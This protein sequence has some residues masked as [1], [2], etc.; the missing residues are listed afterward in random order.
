MAASGDLVNRVKQRI[1]SLLKGKWRL[2]KLLGVGGMAAVYA[3]VHRNQNRVAIKMLHSELSVDPAM[4]LRFLREGYAANTV[5]H[6][7]A[8]RVFDDDV[9][10]DGA[11]FLVMELLE[12]ETLETRAE[13]LGG[14]LAPGELL[15]LADRLLDVLAAAHAKGIVHRDIKP[16][17][18]FLTT[19][20]QLKVLDF[21]IARLRELG[22]PGGAERP[23]GGHKTVAGTFLGTPAFM[24][25]EQARGRWDEV[26]ERTDLWAVGAT[27]FTLLSGNSVHEART[28]NEQLVLAVTTHAPSLAQRA[29]EQPPELVRLIDR[30]L[31][32][33]KDDRFQHAR[34]MQA[35]LRETRALVTPAP[36]PRAPPQA[37]SLTGGSERDL[38]T[39]VAPFDSVSGA[40]AV[41]A[42]GWTSE[43]RRAVAAA[44]SK[45]MI[46]VAGI[47]LSGLL[48]LVAG[49]FL[50]RRRAAE[51]AEQA[52][53]A[54]QALQAEQA[55]RAEEAMRAERAKSAEQAERE[56]AVAIAAPAPVASN[57]SHPSAQKPRVAPVLPAEKARPAPGERSSLMP[58]PKSEPQQNPFDRR[59]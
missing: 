39:I 53:R 3:A 36:D 27:M 15:L 26:D 46:W 57:Q 48:L 38:A 35:A 4:R 55:L 28:V 50:S 7:G 44:K 59:H 18:L 49:L 30:A 42:A 11:A 12:G 13:R 56:V 32:Y 10:D 22:D 16:D 14:K 1:G 34:E 47:C 41:S 52:R 29:P 8:V 43:E 51:Q 9:T 5:D 45:R 21:G 37:D 20:G 54:E 19:G 58:P 31:A 25:P 23:G 33:H 24:S 6:P 17:N 2:E 40:N